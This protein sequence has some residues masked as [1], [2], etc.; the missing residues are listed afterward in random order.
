M[1]QFRAFTKTISSSVQPLANRSQQWIKEQTGNATEKTELPH[2]YVELETRI[3]A[4]KATHQK[5]L[6][7]TSQY[8]NEAYDYPPNVRESFQDL[9]KSIGEK[10][11]LLSKAGT[12][13]EAQAALTAPPSAKPQP[14]TFS[15]AIARA[16]LSGSQTISTATPQGS[17]EQ[18]P[19]SNGLEKFAISSEK[20][21]EAR[22][23][24]DEKIQGKFLAGWSTTLNQSIKSADKARAAVQNARLNLDAVKSK[25]GTGNEAALTDAQRKSIEAAE[26]VFV[27]KVDE[28]TS[29]MRNVLDTPE[30]LRNLVELA[31]AQ[32]EYHVRAAEILEESVKGLEELQVEQEAEWR[33]ARDEA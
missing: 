4:L 8:A 26:D 24:Q 27:E 30:P 31:K 16:C 15:H 14:K 11:N 23:D 5:L 3:D 25:T 2:D 32:Q 12:A 7:A 22:L 9:G 19:L 29:V 10:V 17:T 20:V 18:D 33:K 28:A 13:A 6:A 21:G 1:D